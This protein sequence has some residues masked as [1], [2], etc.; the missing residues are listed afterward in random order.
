MSDV[1]YELGNCAKMIVVGKAVGENHG[2]SRLSLAHLQ[3]LEGGILLSRNVKPLMQ[4]WHTTEDLTTK[5][6]N[7]KGNDGFYGR[8]E[9]CYSVVVDDGFHVL[10]FKG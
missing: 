6:L 3:C 1:C 7:R 8:H 9:S 2:H 4:S 5:V 10:S